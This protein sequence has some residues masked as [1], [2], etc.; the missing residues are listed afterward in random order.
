MLENE[1]EKE[2]PFIP[3]RNHSHYSILKALPKISL[4]IPPKI[5]AIAHNIIGIVHNNFN[6]SSDMI[7]L[8]Y[9]Q[10]RFFSEC[11]P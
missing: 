11:F 6:I 8:F 5:A 1:N 9:T 4:I 10:A 7:L 2:I 3:L